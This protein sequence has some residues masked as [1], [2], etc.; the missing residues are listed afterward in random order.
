MTVTGAPTSATV[1]A[2]MPSG[3]GEGGQAPVSL[4]HSGKNRML[5]PGLQFA[6]ADARAS[7]L[8]VEPVAPEVVGRSARFEQ[9]ASRRRSFR[10]S[11]RSR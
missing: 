4:K 2:A 7:G 8:V 5:S 11:S 10:R 3:L 1:G 9:R 6:F